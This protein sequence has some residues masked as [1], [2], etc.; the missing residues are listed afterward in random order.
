MLSRIWLCFLSSYCIRI[1][2]DGY[3]LWNCL[4]WRKKEILLTFVCRYVRIF[5][6]AGVPRPIVIIL[7]EVLVFMIFVIEVHVDLW[8]VLYAAQP[9]LWGSL[10][11]KWKLAKTLTRSLDFFK[12]MLMR[13]RVV[14]IIS[15]VLKSHLIFG[16]HHVTVIQWMDIGLFRACFMLK[17]FFILLFVD[18]YVVPFT[19]FGRLNHLV[20]KL[21]VVLWVCVRQRLF[22]AILF[23]DSKFLGFL[24]RRLGLG[25]TCLN[26]LGFSFFLFCRHWFNRHGSHSLRENKLIKMVYACWEIQLLRDLIEHHLHPRVNLRQLS[27][28]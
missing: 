16:Q 26:F 20:N 11:I 15:F 8:L 3:F 17:I 27:E 23:Q 18:Y 10:L 19:R 22:R 21:D 9:V 24:C 1:F 13:T 14:D 4:V 28:T 5:T 25:S 7:I 6:L 12:F 2:Y